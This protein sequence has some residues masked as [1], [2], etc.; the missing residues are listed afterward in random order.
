MSTLEQVQENVRVCS[1]TVGLTDSD[2]AAIHE[3]V[4]RL[5]A[6]LDLY[7]TG[8]GYCMPC[9]SGVEI[10]QIF[11]EY[12]NARIFDYCYV[13]L[14]PARNPPDLRPLGEDARISTES[15]GSPRRC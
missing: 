8:C 7:C 11:A 3:H 4:A 10:S 12:N 1:D 5:R 14:T 15:K 6:M 2:L 13:L 9:P